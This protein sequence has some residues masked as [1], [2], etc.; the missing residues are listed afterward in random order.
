MSQNDFVIADQGFSPMLQDLNSAFQALASSSAG[1]SAPAI[2]YAGQWWLDTANHLMKLRNEANNGWVIVGAFDAVNNRWEV[3]TNVIQ[4]LSGA[5]LAFRNAT[6]AVIATISDAGAGALNGSPVWTDANQGRLG[7]Y[8]KRIPDWDSADTCGWFQGNNAPQ[9]TG[10]WYGNVV[11]HDAGW[12][13]QTVHSVA[14][15]GPSD[16]M[17]YR[18]DKNAGGWGNWY[19]LRMSEAELDARHALKSSYYESP[20]TA[21]VAAVTSTFAHGLGARPK[22]IELELHCQVAEG[23]YGVGDVCYVNLG[24]TLSGSTSQGT[25][26]VADATNIQ[27][28]IANFSQAFQVINPA[29]GYRMSLTNSKWKIVVK[30]WKS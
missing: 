24:P 13:T 23:G 27:V 22:S 28:T 5:G 29:D 6:G 9:A 4:A 11:A 19:P 1:A 16:T 26:V 10:W 15:D 18:R 3:R 8:A 25:A 14:G 21:I 2:P 12:L 7:I 17:S 30:A 20:Q